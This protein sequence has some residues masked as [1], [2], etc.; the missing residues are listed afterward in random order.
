MTNNSS[1]AFIEAPSAPELRLRSL[2]R[3]LD[4]VDDDVAGFV[5]LDSIDR[6]ARLLRGTNGT[7][8]VSAFEQARGARGARAAWDGSG[9]GWMGHQRKS[10]GLAAPK[11]V[12]S[13]RGC[14]PHGT[15]V[16]LNL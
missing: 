13:A 15:V 2:P 16:T 7:T 3:V 9:F 11:G 8:Y 1:S 6:Q 14:P 5:D 10:P 4:R 12:A